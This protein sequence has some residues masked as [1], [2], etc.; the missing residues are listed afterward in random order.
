MKLRYY[1]ISLLALLAFAT[2]CEEDA[3]TL[4]KEVQ[5][6][7]SYVAIPIE[8]GSTSVTVNATDAWTITEVPAWLT[9]SPT[10]GVA[11]EGTITF[12]ADKA[13]ATNEA[14]IKLACA[15]KTQYINIIQLAEKSEVTP[16]SC[17]EV[18]VGPDSKTYRVSG[19]CTS[20]ANT[21]YGNWY[22]DD[23]TGSIYI[24]G[25]V[26]AAGSYNWSKFGIEVGDKVTVEG[27]KTTYNG[28][29]EL[30]DVS[31]IS[32]V[33]SLIK[34]EEQP[35]EIGKEGGEAFA[36]ITYKGEGYS[37]SIPE[38][39]KS[40]LSVSGTQVIGDT[41]IVTFYAQPNEGGA[42]STTVSLSSAKGDQN[43]TVTATVNQA[44]AIAEVSI[45]EFN[46]AEVGT[47]QYKITGIIT[48]VAKASY[49]NF[50]L[51]DCTGET[52]V[53]GLGAKGDFENLGLK[54]GDIVTV[55][56]TRGEYNGTI[57][58]LGGQYVS[59]TSV[60]TS[61]IANF[62]AQADGTDWY[63][64]TGT[65]REATEEEVAAGCK[66]DMVTYGNF[67]LEDESGS[68]YVYGV[69]TGYN[70]V[71]KQF[72]TLG[73]NLGD[74]LTILC[75]KTTYKGL[76]EANKAMYVSHEVKSE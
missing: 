29:V 22:L 37:F 48:K 16:S 40:W 66:N 9:V 58:M 74:V 19:T 32:V 1:I 64:L 70:G 5:L 65:V 71:S 26:D 36:K 35:A 62:N 55:I 7:S 50:Y 11:G 28:T 61:T 76:I 44:G 23:G 3:P 30:V 18:I 73:V 20:I 27:P 2:S 59:H 42:R 14:T 43:S 56:G 53:Y 33:K 52:Y 24:Y 41:T 39:D 47:A 54:E 25:T 8:G 15:G 21:Q 6:S 31:V 72:G 67:V 4:L 68:V 49:G 46:A 17:A 12:K 60:T 13:S 57:E 38:D 10:E 69:T 51:K 75:Q 34:V 63:M 45:A